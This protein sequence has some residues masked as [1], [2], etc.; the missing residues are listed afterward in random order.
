M[1][2]PF[3][4]YDTPYLLAAHAIFLGQFALVDLA[5]RVFFPYLV[6]LLVRQFSKGAPLSRFSQ[7]KSKRVSGILTRGYP[8][9]IFYS[10][11]IL[12]P[13]FVIH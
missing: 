7:S 2:P 13:V 11:V 1:I 10:V 9:E 8:F 4:Q 3:K 12:Y 5:F 6:Y